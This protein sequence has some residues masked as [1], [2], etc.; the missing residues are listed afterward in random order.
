M[1]LVDYI[2]DGGDGAEELYDTKR[3]AVRAAQRLANELRQPIDVWRWSRPARDDDMQLDE[4]F[5]LTVEP[6]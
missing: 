6:N 3:E 2:V 5:R 4:A 1:K